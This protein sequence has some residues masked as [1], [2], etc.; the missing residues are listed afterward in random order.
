[1]MIPQPF[2]M[3]HSFLTVVNQFFSEELLRFFCEKSHIPADPLT[4]RAITAN[5]I[6]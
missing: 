6:A 1:M 2:F 3:A 4:R 5:A